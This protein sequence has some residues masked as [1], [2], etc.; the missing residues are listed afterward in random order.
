MGRVGDLRRVEVEAGNDARAFKLKEESVATRMI[1]AC[2]AG[3]LALGVGF[4]SASAQDR[5]EPRE[6]ASI[7]YPVYDWRTPSR[8]AVTEDMLR[9]LVLGGGNNTRHRTATLSGILCDR[10]RFAEMATCT[11]TDD[12]DFLRDEALR[13]YDVI[14][15][16]GWRAPLHG[17]SLEEAHKDGLLKFMGRGGGLVTTHVGNGSFPDWPE[18]GRMVGMQYIDSSS[19][20]TAEGPLSVVAP[21]GPEDALAPAHPA[22]RGMSRFTIVDELQLRLVEKAPVNVVASAERPTGGNQP[23]AWTTDYGDRQQVFV[24]SLGHGLEAWNNEYFLNMVVGALLWT[25]KRSVERLPP[26]PG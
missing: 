13:N 21:P 3:V 23:V 24:T 4:G 20:H 7:E 22:T 15:I 18:F 25:S 16:N 8:P 5:P 11:Q 19:T 9:V 12:L 17:G 10:L 26:P 2:L 6:N 14:L 1:A